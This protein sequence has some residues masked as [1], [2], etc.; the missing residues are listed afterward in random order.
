MHDRLTIAC[1][2]VRGSAHSDYPIA[3][4]A[5]GDAGPSMVSSTFSSRTALTRP[6]P[7]LASYATFHCRRWAL[8]LDA[9]MLKICIIAIG[10]LSVVSCG[11]ELRNNPSLLTFGI[12]DGVKVYIPLSRSYLSA[13]YHDTMLPNQ[14]DDW[15]YSITVTFWRKDLD[16]KSN[17]VETETESQFVDCG[18]SKICVVVPVDEYFKVTV[19]YGKGDYLMSE[20]VI[21]RY[22]RTF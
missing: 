14:I 6:H 13:T 5:L 1:T 16:G 9:T 20:T 18:I 4:H 10:L 3:R 7:P 12:H 22:A 17:Y 2:G 15:S 19:T 21:D 8:A 11:R